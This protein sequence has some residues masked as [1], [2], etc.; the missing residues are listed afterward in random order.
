M[1]AFPAGVAEQIGW[2]IYLYIDPRNEEVFYVGK[3]KDDRVFAHLE[4][5]SESRKV[6]RIAAIRTAGK[7]PRL[8]ILRHS[9]PDETTALLVE[10]VVIDLLQNLPLTNI[11]KG[12]HSKQLGQMPVEEIS[13]R[14][15]SKPVKIS[16]KHKVVLIRVNQ[17]FKTLMNPDELYDATRGV[18]EAG[19]RADEAEYAFTVYKGVVREV[20]R[21]EKWHPA[22]ST[23][24]KTRLPESV[25]WEG[26]WEFTGEVAEASVRQKYLLRSVKEY[27]PYGFAG[28][29][30]YVNC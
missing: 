25:D 19:T 20:Y 9:L 26:R 10:S 14:Y 29:L 28:S 21:I 11:V 12:H 13:A 3:G 8:E 23:S 18:W 27:L 16:S 7:E 17:L 15:A 2:Y 30:R 4:D 5:E 6:Q 24:Y 1:K 22:G